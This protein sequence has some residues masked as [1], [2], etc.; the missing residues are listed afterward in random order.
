MITLTAEEIA[1]H[2]QE[3]ILFVPPETTVYDSVKLIL[4]KKGTAVLVREKEKVTGIWTERD[5]LRDVTLVGFDLKTA[6]IG[7][8][9]SSPVISAP[10]NATVFQL[11][12]KFLGLSVRH[13]MI[14]RDGEFIGLLYVR[15]VIRAALTERTIEFEELN[16]MVSW[17]YYEDWKWKKKHP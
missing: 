3:E 7:D 16:K 5:L 11:I 15:E 13:L 6:K 17:E 12:D 9:M 14:E 1:R 8:Y 4:E 2:R 10:H